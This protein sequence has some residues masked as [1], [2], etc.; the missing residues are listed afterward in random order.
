MTEQEWRSE[1]MY[2]IGYA[3]GALS[4]IASQ[5]PEDMKKRVTG[6]LLVLE[7]RMKNLQDVAGH[8][9]V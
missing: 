8:T 1:A 2:L 5:I 4:A 7:E 6:N 3:I 9:P